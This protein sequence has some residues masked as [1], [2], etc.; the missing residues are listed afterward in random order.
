MLAHI[1]AATIEKRRY[2]TG[3]T[4]LLT[5]SYTARW[6]HRPDKDEL[7]TY[8]RLLLESLKASADLADGRHGFKLN[9]Q[10]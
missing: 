1:L 3:E 7:M 8:Y 4:D 10:P 2:E 5:R 6:V 9:P